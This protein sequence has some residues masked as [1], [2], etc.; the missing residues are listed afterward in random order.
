MAIS[1]F[2][3]T[4]AGDQLIFSQVKARQLT[5]S[6][7]ARG[8]RDHVLP[9][10]LRLSLPPAQQIGPLHHPRHR[11]PDDALLDQAQILAQGEFTLVESEKGDVE[12][13]VVGQVPSRREL[14]S[15]KLERGGIFDCRLQKGVT[16]DVHKLIVS[17]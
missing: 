4:G 2:L 12:Q 17:T 7:P 6:R 10:S 13:H 14:V 15:R 16:E 11:V 5:P 9:H 8:R 3:M 1:F